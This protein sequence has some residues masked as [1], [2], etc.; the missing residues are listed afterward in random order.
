MRS[1]RTARHDGIADVYADI[2]EESGAYV[3]QEVCVL[4]FSNQKEAWLDVWAY[5][6][7]ELPDC[8]VDVTVRHPHS[9]RYLPS[10]SRSAGHAA[11]LAEKQ[12]DD[13]Y[14]T[15]QGRSVVPAAHETWGRLGSSAEALLARCAAAASR[16]SRRRGKEP[17]NCLRRWRAQLDAALMR[18]IATQLVSARCGVPGRARRRVPPRFAL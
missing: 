15:S 11:G 1:F 17:G 12:K 8:L 3:R 18:G 2:M 14:P 6:V 9:D 10:A 5:G 7:P 16:R 4:E 13:R